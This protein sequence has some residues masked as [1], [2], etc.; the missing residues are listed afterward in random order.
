[1]CILTTKLWKPRT[2]VEERIAD[3]NVNFIINHTVPKSMTLQEIKDAT[4]G[5]VT[6]MKVQ[7][8]LKTGK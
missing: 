5:D 3:N 6:L 7:E 8:C 1:M 2:T 4:K